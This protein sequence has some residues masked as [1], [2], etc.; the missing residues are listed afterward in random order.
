MKLK[1][2]LALLAA[3]LVVPY[4]PSHAEDAYPT[5]PVQIILPFA[6]GGSLSTLGLALGHQLGTKWPYQPVIEARPGAGGNIGAEAVAR[7]AADGYTLLFGTQALA[8]NATLIPSPNFDP[9]KSF[10]SV[11][12]IGTGQNVLVVPEASPFK[13]LMDVIDAARAQLGKLNAATVGIGSTSYLATESFEQAAGINVTL[14]PYNG[15]GPAATDLIAGRTDFWITT[16][17]SVLPNIQGGQ[18]RGLAITGDKRAASLPDVPTFAEAGYPNFKGN[19]WFALFAP[20]GTPKSIIRQLTADVNAAL[21]VD[22]VRERFQQASIE[23]IGGTPE[24]LK[25]LMS[26]EVKNWREILTKAGIKPN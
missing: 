11:V 4:R 19:A 5:R 13:S 22:W 20:A 7:S 3:V 26:E 15:A 10:D 14:V 9:E 24:E 8:A 17:V 2:L 6:T 12:L 1:L 21:R 25:T 23:P 18:M 16:L